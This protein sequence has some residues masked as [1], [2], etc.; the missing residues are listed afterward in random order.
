MPLIT[1]FAPSPT[2]PFHIGNLHIA[3]YN[4]LFARKEGGKFLLRI[5]DTDIKRSD[6][7]MT[8]NIIESL[9]WLGLE[10]DGEIYKQSDRFQIYREYAELLIKNKLGYFCYC[11]HEEIEERKQMAMAKK[12]SWKYDRKC[13][14]LANMNEIQDRPRAIRFLVPEGKVSYEDRIHNKMERDAADIEDFV[15]LKS[16]GTPSY[17]FACVIDDHELNITDV[18]RGEDHVVNTFKQVLLYKAL[19]WKAPKFVHLPM[20]LGPDRSKLS[21][22]HGATLVLEYREQGFLPEA[23]IN[24]IALLGW[25]PGGDREF[26]SFPELIELFSL[27]RL[28]PTASIFDIKKLEWMNGEYINKMSDEEVLDRIVNFHENREPTCPD[29][30]CVGKTENRDYTNGVDAGPLTR[31]KLPENRE[32]MLKV[33]NL[34]KPRMQKLTAFMERSAYFFNDPKEY[35][36][37]GMDKYF[38]LPETIERLALVKE[39]FSKLEAFSIEMIELAVRE[40]ADELGIKASLLIHPI[41]LA[42]TG[43]T[44]GPSLFHIVET[45]GKETVIRR[46]EKALAFL[47]KAK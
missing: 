6:T 45:L 41:R 13:L 7:I 39:R 46:L 9:K 25:S 18:I 26:I 44:G 19:G 11:T 4:F 36:K 33:V 1:R 35:D 15:I 32:Y 14:N 2:G 16:D 27:D 38:N 37:E 20:I 8:Q 43:I 10:Y 29:A 34:L 21:K 31:I 3:L 40:L 30:E 23:L 12:E 5:E 17:N 22:R 47:I 24:Y 42:L 28:S